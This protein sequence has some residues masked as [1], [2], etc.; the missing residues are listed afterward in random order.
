MCTRTAGLALA[1]V[2]LSV[3]CG[4]DS[5]DLQTFCR[6][7]AQA[8]D[9]ERASSDPQLANQL[10]DSAPVDVRSAVGRLTSPGSGSE[11]DQDAVRLSDREKV[12]EY[13]ARRCDGSTAT[14]L[15]WRAG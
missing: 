2:L 12:T 15:P 7:T 3:G 10:V 5:G 8:G 11:E 6:L 4:G 9:V 1:V 13:V 14:S